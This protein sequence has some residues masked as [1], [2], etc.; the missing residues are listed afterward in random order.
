MLS[1]RLRR[2]WNAG[3]KGVMGIDLPPSAASTPWLVTDVVL[4]A[5][6]G[7]IAPSRIRDELFGGWLDDFA[8]RDELWAM[9]AGLVSHAEGDNVA[10]VAALAVVPRRLRIRACTRH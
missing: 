10:A 5:L 4:C 9:C 8:Q 6:A 3:F 2:W 1:G 7:G